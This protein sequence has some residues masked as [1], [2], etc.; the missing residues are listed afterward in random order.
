MPAWGAFVQVEP[1]DPGVGDC[2]AQGGIDDLEWHPNGRWVAY[3]VATG[4][5][6]SAIRLCHLPTGAVVNATRGSFQDTCPTFDPRGECVI[7]PACLD[8]VV[9]L[10]A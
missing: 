9:L 5:R 6:T 1:A 3:S 2:A 4:H 7:T 8:S 10:L